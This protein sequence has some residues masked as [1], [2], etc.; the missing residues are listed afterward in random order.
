ML[1]R[2][3]HEVECAHSAGEGLVKLQEWSPECV[4]LD[5]MLPDASGALI[6]RKIRAEKLP[7][8]VA[9]ITAAGKNSPVLRQAMGYD[10]DIVFEK[11]LNH[12]DLRRWLD[13]ITP[14]A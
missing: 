13:H 14:A 2:M 4:L 6:L 11:P 10:P 8:R 3:G 12:H 5:L 1:A 7:V 9:V